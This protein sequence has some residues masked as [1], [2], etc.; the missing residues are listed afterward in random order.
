MCFLFKSFQ[1]FTCVLLYFFKGVIYVLF[2]SSIIFMIIDFKT[3]HS[4]VMQNPGFV[5]VRELS[6]SDAKYP[7]F[8][9]RMFLSLPLAIWLSLL[10]PALVV[11]DWSLS[12]V[13][14][15]CVRTP[16]SPVV[17]AIL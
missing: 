13:I 17:S 16:Q 6:S 1:L 10:L 2:N 14:P 4:G 12:P 7:C 15:D 11:S 9:L 5:V 3:N 8:L